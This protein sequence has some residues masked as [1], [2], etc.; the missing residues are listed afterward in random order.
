[1]NTY[2][3]LD[4]NNKPINSTNKLFKVAPKQ[5]RWVKINLTENYCCDSTTYIVTPGDDSG[6]GVWNV[7]F[8]C[9]TNDNVVKL[10]TSSTTV[11]DIDALV[12]LLNSSF[13]NI[14]KFSVDGTDIKV[15]VAL[16]VIPLPCGENLT[17][18][19]TLDAA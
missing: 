1:M 11:A 5:G 19:I 2:I 6:E 12:A 9:G 14:A 15:V 8:T 4:G 16:G 13:E 3:R 17:V 10:S 7:I 18:T